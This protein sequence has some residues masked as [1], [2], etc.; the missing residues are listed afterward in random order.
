MKRFFLTL[1][2][3]VLLI[4]TARPGMAL[5]LEKN[6]DYAGGSFIEVP[7]V[8]IGFTIPNGWKGILPKGMDM[9]VMTPDNVSY[10]FAFAR[11]A[12]SDDIHKLFSHPIYLSNGI[13]LQPTAKP[14]VAYNEV[15]VPFK[16]GKG[17]NPFAGYGRARLGPD[18][19]A[20][21]FI[22]AGP[23]VRGPALA[24]LLKQL[25]SNVKFFPVAAKGK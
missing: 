25:T 10:I 13:A 18:R 16:V 24:V 20:I 22:A 11:R 14:F 7:K 12:T 19:N 8:G 9:F 5:V 6:K 23:V 15:S 3:A 1:G 4:L 17:Q 21:G 2:M